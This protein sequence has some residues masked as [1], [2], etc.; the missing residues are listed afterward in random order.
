MQIT[1]ALGYDK[2]LVNT[3]DI[4]KQAECL[5][6][7]L[8]SIRDSIQHNDEQLAELDQS[9]STRKEELTSLRRDA[10]Q[11]MLELDTVF[12]AVLEL[13]QTLSGQVQPLATSNSLSDPSSNE[14]QTQ[15]NNVV[16]A[17][18]RAKRIVALVG[19]G[20]STSAGSKSLSDKHI[21]PRI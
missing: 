1:E 2:H 13:N 9:I 15:L 5:R 18:K 10:G 16:N 14:Q 3:K 8:K 17:L 4:A 6:A 20:I 11:Y 21:S 7:K 12:C 19:A